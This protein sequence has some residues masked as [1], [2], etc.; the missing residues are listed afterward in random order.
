MLK[1]LHVD[2]YFSGHL[3][4]YERTKPVCGLNNYSKPLYSNDTI[5]VYE[6]GCPIFVVEGAGGNNYFVE[7]D[8]HCTKYI[9]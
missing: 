5:N 9:M 3:H 1:N 8:R 4:I 2:L 7:K 6:T